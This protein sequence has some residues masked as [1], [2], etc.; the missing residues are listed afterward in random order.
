M[1][2]QYKTNRDSFCFATALFHRTA[3][4]PQRHLG[5]ISLVKFSANVADQDNTRAECIN[6]PSE[7]LLMVTYMLSPP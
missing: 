2:I 3:V 7:L 1:A 4:Q 6:D 5:G